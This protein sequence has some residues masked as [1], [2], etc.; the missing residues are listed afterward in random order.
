MDGLGADGR[1]RARGEGLFEPVESGV[2]VTSGYAN[3][4]VLGMALGDYARSRAR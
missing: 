3:G 4:S 2:A 1:F